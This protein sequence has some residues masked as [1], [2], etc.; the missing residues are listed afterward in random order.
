[1][2]RPP[3]TLLDERATPPLR[4]RIGRLLA[5]ADQ[6]AFA[7]ARVRLAF[8]DLGDE[9]LGSLRR[10][11]V[12]LGH[13][14]AS[15]LLDASD[16]AGRHTHAPSMGRLLRFAN[17]GRL[18]VRSAGLAA[19]TPDFGVVQRD[20]EAMG[21]LGAIQFGNPEL[22]SGPTFTAITTDSDAVALLGRRFDQLWHR[23]HDVLPAIR[24]VLER[25]HGLEHP[26]ATGSGDMDPGADLR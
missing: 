11:R 22:L 18:E 15:N 12:L 16:S 5:G 10:C 23:S 17:S 14:D 21:L 25:A 2:T 1:M 13:L 26:A 7:L 8:V 3:L 19:W 20:A 9:E 4:D 6:A 24:Q